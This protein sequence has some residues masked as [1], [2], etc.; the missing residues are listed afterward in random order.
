[1]SLRSKRRTVLLVAA[2]AALLLA[3]A[4]LFVR[5]QASGYRDQV[6]VLGLLRELRDGAQRW[7][8]D[9]LALAND[10][11]SAEARVPDR[12]PIR[13]LILQELEHGAGKAVVGPEELGRIRAGV[14]EREAAFGALREAHARSLAAHEGARRSLE[15][16]AR[17]AAARRSANPERA[18]ALLEQVASLRAAALPAG[19]ENPGAGAPAREAALAAL[20][21]AAL[22]VDPALGEAA[23]G[24]Q[25]AAAELFERRAAEAEAWRR[26]TFHPGGSRPELLAQTL[27]RSVEAALD[28]N[29]RWR[30]YLF[31]YAAALL[32]G[33]GYLGARVIAAQ[34]ALRRANEELE[35][36]VEART[37]E[38]RN[39]L[40]QL[41]ESEAQLVQTEKMSS[42]G[43]LVAGV[44]HEI[45]TPLAYVKNSVATVR[46]R[47]PE[48]HEALDSAE[49]LLA[50]LR[51][52][53]PDPAE[54]H[55]TFDRLGAR[56]ARLA[57]HEVLSDLDALT[58]D[59]LHGIEQISELVSNL[60]NFSRLDRSR[61][62]S[63][64][65]NEGVNA[66]LLIA[67][68]A[69]RKVDVEKRLGELPSITCSPSQVNQ[70]LL[71]I[72]TNAAQAIDKPRGRISI[73]TRR[74]G[75]DH[76]AIEVSDDGR[77]I[78]PEALPRIFDPF[79]TTK[80]P[81]QGT[82]LGLSIAYKI[83]SQ[84]GGRIDVRSE[85][86]VGTTF[87]VRLPL[88]ANPAAGEPASAPADA[89][90]RAA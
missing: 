49:R 67:K 20:L 4:F 15:A 73:A 82:G 50:L 52:E 36:R 78:V 64:N 69:L 71:N 90:A 43:Q 61:V 21:P 48:L 19:I 35:A 38:L 79:Y 63:F 51:E 33:V 9:A 81:G 75:P 3:L 24:A 26:F 83:V 2:S 62:A 6:H 28:D 56:L 53:S 29:D 88:H 60:K 16:L 37:G 89:R 80:A 59:G 76:V 17:Q 14:V 70:V 66:V 30:A 34:G 39:T 5:T 47:M 18:A 42:L 58:R 32:V 54:L 22:A 10:F 55:A 74:D 86:D 27:A 85:V 65:V 72:V 7:D 11:T 31:A 46:D 8:S 68:A 57:E 41:R 84:H 87:T 44:A 12:A 77:G 23:R 40:E 1:M 13:A 25:A 45:N